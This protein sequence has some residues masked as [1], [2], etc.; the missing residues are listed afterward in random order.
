MTNHLS[1]IVLIYLQMFLSSVAWLLLQLPRFHPADFPLTFIVQ[2]FEGLE[3]SLLSWDGPGF[4]ILIVQHSL[5]AWKKFLVIKRLTL[6]EVRRFFYSK[7]PFFLWNP[8]T[9]FCWYCTS[10]ITKLLHLFN[11]FLARNVDY[12]VPIHAICHDLCFIY[13][14]YVTFILNFLSVF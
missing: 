3:S 14:Y 12:V 10:E 13:I 1:L 2:Q 7:L 8:A 5:P 11:L 9:F 4:F 6:L